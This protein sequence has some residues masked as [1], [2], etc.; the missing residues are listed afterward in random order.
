MLLHGIIFGQ[1]RNLQFLAENHGLYK[2][3]VRGFTFCIPHCCREAEA[4]L[5]KQKAT[6]KFIDEFIV[7]REEVLCVM[8]TSHM[9]ILAS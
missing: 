4:R 6:R 1:N 2:I 5:E 8:Y 7:K 3:I 9:T